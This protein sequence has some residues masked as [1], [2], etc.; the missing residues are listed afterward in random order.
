MS[1]NQRFHPDCVFCRICQGQLPAAKVY[2]DEQVLAFLDIAPLADGHVL[3]IPTRHVTLAS[4]CDPEVL[5]AIGRVIPR[6]AGAVVAA[7]GAEGFNVLNNNGRVAGQAVGHLHFHIIPRRRGDPLGYRW[8]AMHDYP[9]DK[10]Q[11]FQAGIT[12]ALGG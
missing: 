6:L 4:E 7:T 5:A 9:K 1:R 8:P 10:L 3:I 2:E 12:A 11:K